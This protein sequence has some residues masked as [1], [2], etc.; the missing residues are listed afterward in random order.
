MNYLVIHYK[1]LA[2]QLQYRVN[3]LQRFLYEMNAAAGGG[4]NQV[5]A[6]TSANNNMIQQVSPAQNTPQAGDNPPPWDR[7]TPN[8]KRT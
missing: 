6:N 8:P 3:H 4:L 1:N 7:G 2:E 5:G